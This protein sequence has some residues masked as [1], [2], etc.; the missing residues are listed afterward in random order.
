MYLQKYCKCVSENKYFAFKP[1]LIY[2]RKSVIVSRCGW[3][4]VARRVWVSEY[5]QHCSRRS[6][7]LAHTPAL[8]LQ[9]HIHISY[10]M[11]T[12]RKYFNLL[13]AFA[14]MLPYSY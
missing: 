14:K 2:D 7:S 5:L 6:L 13:A 10:L 4:G 12:K 9:P 3:V 11:N 8:P 1:T